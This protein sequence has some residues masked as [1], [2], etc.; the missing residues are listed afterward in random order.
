MPSA[1]ITFYMALLFAPVP[2]ERPVDGA[3][4][5]LRFPSAQATCAACEF[6]CEYERH[7]LRQRDLGIG[8]RNEL[9]RAWVSNEKQCWPAWNALKNAH[10]CSGS[11]RPCD[12]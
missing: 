6:C 5:L 7:L 4:E 12:G 11:R 10:E 3:A 1:A 9:Y 8:D 2:T